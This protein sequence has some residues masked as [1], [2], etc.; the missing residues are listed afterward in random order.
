MRIPR[1]AIFVSLFVVSLAGASIGVAQNTG[2][3]ASPISAPA[4]PGMTLT[5][6]SLSGEIVVAGSDQAG[7]RISCTLEDTGRA[8]EVRMEFEKT[9]DFGKLRVHGNSI[10]NLKVRIEVPRRTSLKLRAPAGE[11]RVEQVSGDKDIA[12]SAGEVQV[13]GVNEAEYRE[14]KAAVGVG[15]V[16]AS[17]FG[18]GKGGFFRKFER[19]SPKGLYRLRIHIMTGNIQLD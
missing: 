6:E 4:R 7:I 11:V 12:I 1:S 9:G 8:E 5:V 19:D 18:E 16:S 13:S 3:C 2:S 15:A 14:V 17:E 10:N